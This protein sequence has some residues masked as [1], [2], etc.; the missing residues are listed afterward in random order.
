M[1]QVIG[2][3][4]TFVQKTNE[5]LVEAGIKR[6]ELA[7]LDHI[8]YRVETLA[9][10]KELLKLLGGKALL[11][12][13]AKISGRMIATFEFAEPLGA[14][15][16]RIP[17]LELP[18]PK[19]GSPYPEGLEHAEF[20]VVG[21]LERFLERHHALPF[22]TTGLGKTLNPE[23]GL[24]QEGLSVKFHEAQLGAVIG[25]EDRLEKTN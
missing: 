24:K 5:S 7:M 25:I 11:L 9:R 17:Y 8:C 19:D 23:I 22:V 1:K 16:W 6:S 10:Y 13:E 20:V 3:Y 15:G 2:D 12:G 21:S 18:Q 14:D 4:E